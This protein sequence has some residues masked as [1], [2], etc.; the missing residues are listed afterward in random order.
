MDQCMIDL[1]DIPEAR[2]GDEVVLLG[3]SSDDVI[4]LSELADKIDTNRNE[5]LSII[6]RR[7]PRVYIE[8]NKVVQVIDYILD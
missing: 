1:T 8:N 4:T 2:E 3:E 6:G 7:V 5:I